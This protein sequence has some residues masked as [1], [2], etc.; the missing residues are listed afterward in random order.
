MWPQFLGDICSPFIRVLGHLDLGRFMT[1][2]CTIAFYE[3]FLSSLHES[4]NIKEYM[5]F[6]ASFS[7]SVTLLRESYYETNRYL[8]IKINKCLRNM[9]IIAIANI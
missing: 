9:L 2:K 4:A 6:D 3:P 7:K 1:L 8:H 5:F